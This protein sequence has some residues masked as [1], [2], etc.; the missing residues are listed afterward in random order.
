MIRAVAQGKIVFVII[1]AKG[2]ARLPVQRNAVGGDGPI[3]VELVTAFLPV[4]K[5]SPINAEHPVIPSIFYRP[6]R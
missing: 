2:Q 6:A 4:Q 1:G 3:E 5:G